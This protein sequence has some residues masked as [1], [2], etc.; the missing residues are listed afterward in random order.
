MFALPACASEA[1]FP[2]EASRYGRPV[3]SSPCL[4]C[5]SF[6]LRTCTESDARLLLPSAWWPG[7]PEPRFHP[8]L[9]RYTGRQDATVQTLPRPRPGPRDYFP[10]CGEIRPLTAPPVSRRDCRGD[11]APGTSSIAPPPAGREAP[12]IDGLPL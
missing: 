1:P 12:H 5:I 6:P 10:E 11:M 8:R 7:S 3:S 2:A 4:L 9:R